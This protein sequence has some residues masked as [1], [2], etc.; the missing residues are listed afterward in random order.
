MP[1]KQAKKTVKRKQ[2]A[3]VRITNNQTADSA[4]KFFIENSTFSYFRRG[5]FGILVLAK[6]KE[7]LVSPYRNIRLNNN[8]NSVN[9][10][11]LKFVNITPSNDKD[12]QDIK[13]EDV[14]REIDIQQEIYHKSLRHPNTLLEPICPCIVYSHAEKLEPEFKNSF[15]TIIQQSTHHKQIQ[16]VFQGDVAF[17][18][19]EFM[20]GYQPFASFEETPFY[21]SNK[22]MALYTLD[23]LHE[24]GFMHNDLHDENV[25]INTT[26]NYFWVDSGRAI[27]IDFGRT[28]RIQHKNVDDKYRYRLLAQETV[29]IYPGVISSFKWLD[30]NHT[31][32]QGEYVAMIE[33]KYNCNIQNII[34]K[35]KF[36]IGGKK[37]MSESKF[38][39]IMHNSKTYCTEELAIKYEERLKKHNPE[40]YIELIDNIKETKDMEKKIP[41]YFEKLLLAQFDGL[42]DPAFDPVVANANIEKPKFELIMTR[43]K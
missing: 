35:Y 16:Q 25:L 23:K 11:L 17:F 3:G 37:T 26:Y 5:Y 29:H 40:K 22:R 24:L 6:L 42:I 2:K 10:L 8:N 36:Y 14:Q 30:E 21:E 33:K 9:Y 32:I 1:H 13:P 20:E 19:M 39:P 12:I 43:K 7:G 28:N 18:A 31:K 38:T 4:F 27:I 41:N 15:Y 34:N